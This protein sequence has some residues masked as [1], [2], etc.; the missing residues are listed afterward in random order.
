MY[1]MT[2]KRRC[3]DKKKFIDKK[4]D[5]Y[6]IFILKNMPKRKTKQQHTSLDQVIGIGKSRPKYV[7]EFLI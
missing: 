1:K 2:I 4:I 7:Y 5:D 6:Y 3:M